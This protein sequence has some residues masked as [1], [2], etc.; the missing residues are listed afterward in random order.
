M[1]FPSFNVT[2]VCKLRYVYVL[3]LKLYNRLRKTLKLTKEKNQ[4]VCADT[5]YK[6]GYLN[7]KM[8]TGS[9]NRLVPNI[10]SGWMFVV[11]SPISR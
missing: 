5:D 2:E 7:L 11:Q 4:N 10:N 6:R 3:A 8:A 1:H 9:M